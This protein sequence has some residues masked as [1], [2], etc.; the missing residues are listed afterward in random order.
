MI[1]CASL[2]QMCLGTRSRV[3]YVY[4]SVPPTHP[5]NNF[6]MPKSSLILTK[7]SGKF[8]YHPPRWSM[9]SKITRSLKS[10]V[11]NRPKSSMDVRDSRRSFNHAKNVKLSIQAN[12]E[13]EDDLWHQRWPNHIIQVS[14]KE[15]STPSKSLMDRSQ[16]IDLMPSNHSFNLKC[17]LLWG[18]PDMP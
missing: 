9:M 10:P 2:T 4:D 3:P 15:P 8:Y 1:K 12:N 11:R 5:G 6:A 18:I 13:D 7:H 16:E 14:S 17:C